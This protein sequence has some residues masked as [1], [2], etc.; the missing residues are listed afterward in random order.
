MS[1]QYI[2]RGLVFLGSAFIFLIS[3]L[4]FAI[5]LYAVMPPFWLPGIYVHHGASHVGGI[6][7]GSLVT[8]PIVGLCACAGC[9]GACR[10]KRKLLWCF[11]GI[12]FIG[13]LA[14][15]A[16]ATVMW[17]TD[18]TLEAAQQAAFNLSQMAADHAYMFRNVYV[19]FAA[20]YRFCAPT[21]ASSVWA[22]LA[23]GEL[24]KAGLSVECGE[25]ALAPFGRWT[26]DMC[27]R[28]AA[29]WPAV[30]IEMVSFCRAGLNITGIAAIKD[31]PSWLFCACA[32][33]LTSHIRRWLRPSRVFAVVLAAYLLM[34]LV[35][36]C[37]LCKVLLSAPKA[38]LVWHP[39]P[40]NSPL[41]FVHV[42]PLPPRPVSTLPL[43]APLANTVAHPNLLNTCCWKD[44]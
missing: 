16:G 9:I 7:F 24:A 30:R 34:L 11:G 27:V 13:F 37:I 28:D 39:R 22:P 14:S 25:P 38:A 19:E 29:A 18:A 21:N 35:L 44:S 42:D 17:T 23:A 2:T 40:H 33:S 32:P 43:A 3:A 12:V 20:V 1:D 41:V 5:G 10:R 8:G 36:L 6:V 26:T 15:A 31:D 4:V